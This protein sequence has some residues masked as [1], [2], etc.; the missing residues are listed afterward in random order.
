MIENGQGSF[1]R[2]PLAASFRN[3][4]VDG[5]Q[6]KTGIAIADGF[7]H[8]RSA[9]CRNQLCRHMGPIS[10]EGQLIACAP[11]KVMIRIEVA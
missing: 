11:N 6:G 2:I 9:A 5:P 7:V 10:Q 3:V 8:V 4:L 1:D